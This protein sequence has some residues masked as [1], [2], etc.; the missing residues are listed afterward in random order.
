MLLSSHELNEIDQ[1]CDSILFIKSGC[2][3]KKEEFNAVVPTI[4]FRIMLAAPN[5]SGAC[6]PVRTYCDIAVP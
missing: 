4:D 1:L 5:R 3:L 2:I 6:S